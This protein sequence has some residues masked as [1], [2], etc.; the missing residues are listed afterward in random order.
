M[1]TTSLSPA[2]QAHEVLDVLRRRI[3]VDGFEIVV[4]PQACHDSYMHDAV[5]GR[6]FLDFYSFFASMPLSF[7]HEKLGDPRYQ[8]DLLTAAAVK[9]ANADVYSRYYAQFVRTLDE[10]A[11][12]DGFTHFF[13]IDGG[14][15]AVE[16]A[17]KAA[18]DWKIRKN[19]AAGRGEIGSQVIHFKQAFHGRTGYTMSLTNTVDPRKTMYF[20]KFQWP[21]IDNPGINFALA[22]PERSADVK[23]REEN[24][25]QQ[26]HQAIGEHG[27]DIAAMIIEPIQGEGG[28]THF[29]PEFLQRLR[30]ICDEHEM[31]LIFD[32]VQTGVGLTGSMWAFEQMGVTPDIFAFGKKM[33]QCGIMA[34]PRIDEV[35]DNVFK[36]PSRINSTWGGNLPDMVRASQLLKI[37]HE[38]DLVTRAAESGAILLEHLERLAEKHDIVTAPR[39][40]GLMCAFDL[41]DGEL[42][43]TVRK[44]CYENDML[45]LACGTRSLRFRPVLDVSQDELERGIEILDV[46]LRAAE[47]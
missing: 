40:R 6:E 35:E 10:V 23:A 27:H 13:F 2:V 20:P 1:E 17:L 21:R 31:L 32:E 46:A 29:R 14:A 44:A 11:A 42:R 30:D 19:L 33:Q 37:I 8:A 34:G 36:V 28:D 15:L 25:I 22:E 5:S 26:I 4:D 18:F 7:N 45:V 47:S 41:P 38:D 9:V 12:P 39:G 24:A 43:A 3:L 16:N